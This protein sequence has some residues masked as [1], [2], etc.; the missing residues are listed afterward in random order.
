MIAVQSSVAT[1]EVA[2]L[3]R[4]ARVPAHAVNVVRSVSSSAE[5]SAVHRLN[6]IA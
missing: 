6:S 3:P 4:P 5:R 1:D 2:R